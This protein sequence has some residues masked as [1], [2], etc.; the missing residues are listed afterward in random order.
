VG[1]RVAGKRELGQMTPFDLVVILLIANA[2]Q[3]AMVGP[4]T[5]VTGGLIAAAVLIGANHVVAVTRERLPW[6]R[7]AV[8]GSPTLLI[9]DG[10]FVEDHLRGEGLDEDDVLM[11][12]R[13]HGID[14]VSGVQTAV[15]EV[16]GSISIV[17]RGSDVTRTRRHR[18]F[19]K[20]K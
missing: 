4:D 14:D 9:N 13:E 19:L 5:S 8:Q 20:K 15:L 3:N 16:D 6:L 2:V 1:L 17:P 11:A 10:V 18:R 12:I 7:R